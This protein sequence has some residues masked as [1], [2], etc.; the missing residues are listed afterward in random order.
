[1]V[2]LNFRKM[3]HVAVPFVGN[4]WGYSLYEILYYEYDYKWHI[5]H[6]YI[7]IIPDLMGLCKISSKIRVTNL[8]HISLQC[9]MT[10]HDMSSSCM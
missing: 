8:T 1:M 7:G 10:N 5:Q 9:A 2:E 4:R 6:A 3:E